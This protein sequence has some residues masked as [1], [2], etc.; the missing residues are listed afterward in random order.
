MKDEIVRFAIA[1]AHSRNEKIF[2]ALLG[3]DMVMVNADD[4][5]ISLNEQLEAIQKESG[6]LLDLDN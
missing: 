2:M 5:A 3:L 1:T 6:S 4:T